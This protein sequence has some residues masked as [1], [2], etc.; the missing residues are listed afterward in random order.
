MLLPF[1]FTV[2]TIG[3]ILQKFLINQLKPKIIMRENT[4]ALFLLS[5]CRKK[6][7][8]PCQKNTEL[9]LKKHYAIN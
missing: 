1:A 3:E 5:F 6:P 4:K 8:Q 2:C 9:L 7:G